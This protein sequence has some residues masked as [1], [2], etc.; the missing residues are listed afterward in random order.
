MTTF[1]ELE[2][3]A[4]NTPV[5]LP[6]GGAGRRMGSSKPK[7]LVELL[8]K[9]LIDWAIEYFA[10]SGF[11]EFVLLLG[12]GAEQVIEHLERNTRRGIKMEYSVDPEPRGRVGKAVA[13]RRAVESGLVKGRSV[14]AF[15]D[16][17]FLDSSL[18][19][20]LLLAHLE[21]ARSGALATAVLASG[22]R[23][24]FGVARV[25]SDGLV[26][27]FEEKP[28]LDL[29]VNAGMYALEGEALRLLL[30]LVPPRPA[31]PVELETTLM[32]EL[33]RRRKLASL[34]VPASRW[35][36]INTIKDLEEAEKILS[37]L[38]VDRAGAEEARP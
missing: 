19:L 8:G 30:D 12:Y 36:P 38:A 34:I 18:P 17:L 11:R 14:I 6:A 22:Y 20:R 3:L 21:H 29:L 4:A 5:V 23:L 26:E 24:P 33:A 32:P 15:P 7:P 1:R 35:L 10:S 31:E 13:L 9:P 16:D 28:R 37:A 25:G 27:G 2:E